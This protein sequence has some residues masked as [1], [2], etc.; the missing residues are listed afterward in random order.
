MTKT[1]RWMSAVLFTIVTLLVP[2]VGVQA[3]QA[4]SPLKVSFTNMTLKHD[5]ARARQG[6]AAVGGNDT[7]RYE[8]TFTNAEKRALSNV[9]FNNPIPKGLQ[10]VGGTV[11]TSA[12]AKVEYSIDGGMEYSARPMMTVLE[13]GRTVQRIAPTMLYT[14]IR[15]TVTDSVAPG[16]TVTARFDAAVGVRK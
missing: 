10:L 7:L 11:T 14:H 8:L 4:K 6:A 15:W 2:A 5:S 12:G 1:N 13:N 3:Q 16:A 9:V